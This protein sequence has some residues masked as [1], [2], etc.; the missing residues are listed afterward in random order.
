[1]T[2][3]CI[4]K[5]IFKSRKIFWGGDSET[6]KRKNSRKFSKALEEEIDG[7]I[8]KTKQHI[9]GEALGSSVAVLTCFS[10]SVDEGCFTRLPVDHCCC[11]R[12]KNLQA[13]KQICHLVPTL[14]LISQS[15]KFTQAYF[16]SNLNFKI[17]L[18][19]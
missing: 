6:K 4:F 16:V 8:S 3:Y 5:N 18:N 2:Y 17:L 13:G 7:S 11:C 12:P 10:S 19:F 9:L 14:K 15:W 1:M